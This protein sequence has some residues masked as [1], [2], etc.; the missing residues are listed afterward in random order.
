MKQ[1]TQLFRAAAVAALATTTCLGADVR[2]G[3]VSY[4]PLDSLD[5]VNLITPD[6]VASNNLSAVGFSDTSSLV[7]GRFGQALAFDRT[8]Q[9][10]AVLT[11]DTNVDT[12]LPITRNAAY[13]ILFWV[14]ANATGQSDLRCF[15]EAD[16]GDANNNPLYTVGTQQYGTNAFP[17]FYLRN[18]PGTV[19]VDNTPTNAVFDGT[20]H[21]V[22]LVYDG[23]LFT[24]FRD[25]NV[26]YTNRYTRDATGVW[27]T[28]ALGAIVRAAPGSFF[29][30]QMDDV[31]V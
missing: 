14:N 2:S 1:K 11:G 23:N 13:S 26:I 28:T 18:S 22:A 21:H 25:G 27:D 31:A 17:R 4:W 3:L 6:V 24:V 7:P 5:L 19:L 10:Y 8:V 16:V 30:G 15:S 9:Q 29:S 20:W 12:G